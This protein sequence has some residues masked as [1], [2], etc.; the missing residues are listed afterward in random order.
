[1]Q[2]APIPHPSAITESDCK[3]TVNILCFVLGFILSEGSYNLMPT[4]LLQ[5]RNVL[6][7]Q[8][9]NKKIQLEKEAG[10]IKART[11]DIPPE[12]VR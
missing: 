11:E 7:L 6:Q 4:G 10:F 1:M 2:Q 12:H 3:R 5:P 9:T 8:V